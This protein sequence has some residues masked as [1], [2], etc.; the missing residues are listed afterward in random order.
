MPWLGAITAVG[1]VLLVGLVVLFLR[2]RTRDLVDEYVKRRGASSR[3]STRADYVE[4]M[5]RIPV[6]LALTAD[7]IYYE[8]PDLQASIDLARID[9]IEYDDETATGQNV[10][11]KV[12]RVR[13]H[14]HTF[15][16]V[17]D[18]ESARRWE[19]ALPTHHV[20]DTGKVRAS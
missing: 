20:D 2:I 9:E 18:V 4:G 19:A 3:L 13:S 1:L 5:Q 11:G 8:N 17:V 15:E 12:V 16:F 7:T 10:E 6:A 14:G